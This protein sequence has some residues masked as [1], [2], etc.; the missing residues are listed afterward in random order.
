MGLDLNYA[1]G[2]SK[3][4][5]AQKK[6]GRFFKVEDGAN[7]LRLFTFESAVTGGTALERQFKKHFPPGQDPVC[8]AKIP[9]PDEA[10]SIAD[11]CQG[12]D[13]T[14]KISEEENEQA[15]SK[16]DGR[17]KY[18]INAVPLICGGNP[19]EGA[20]AMVVYEMPS[21][22]FETII[23]VMQTKR[24]P[25]SLFG[26]R[27]RNIVVVY[28]SKADVSRKYKVMFDDEEESKETSARLKEHGKTLLSRVRDLH[29]SPDYNSAW[30]VDLCK[31]RGYKIAGTAPEVGA[32]GETD[33]ATTGAADEV[34]TAPAE[35]VETDAGS[36]DVEEAPVQPSVP[37]GWKAIWSDEEKAFYFK[38]PD[39]KTTWNA[40]TKADYSPEVA[41]SWKPAPGK[42]AA[43]AAVVKPAPA[44]KKGR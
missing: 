15:A 33:T 22:V 23:A 10:G 44:A 25:N 31:E 8:C 39:G 1:R 30:W 16:A 14:A 12:C 43:A 41:L 9:A 32:D 42:P 4:I 21:V 40:P 35:D 26:L 3:R 27:G 24:D 37:R 17:V 38:R 36:A 5:K 29:T 7:H 28:D 13:I 11:D 20:P 19:I 34:K 18:A 2:A 6:G